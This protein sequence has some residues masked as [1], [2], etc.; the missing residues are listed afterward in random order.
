MEQIIKLCAV[1]SDRRD[2]SETV[3]C[4]EGRGVRRWRTKD[5]YSLL[6]NSE[7][8]ANPR[9]PPRSGRRPGPG[10]HVECGP[11][12]KKAELDLVND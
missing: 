8:R 10:R 2:P 6:I 11:G 4:V 5:V 1:H 12:L 3:R 9:I 7:R